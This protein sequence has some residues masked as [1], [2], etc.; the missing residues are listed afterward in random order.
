MSQIQ[1][2]PDPAA[3]PGKKLCVDFALSST[4]FV[5]QKGMLFL[6]V[7]IFPELIHHAALGTVEI[8]FR[9]LFLHLIIKNGS[10]PLGSR[11]LRAKLPTSVAKQRKTS[12]TE[13][14]KTSA[15]SG[16]DVKADAKESSAELAVGAQMRKGE[17]NIRSTGIEDQFSV[18][19][20]V[21]YASGYDSSP[22]WRFKEQQGEAILVGGFSKEKLG[23]LHCATA[24]CGII[25]EFRALQ[26]D[27]FISGASGFFPADLNNSHRAVRKLVIW[28]WLRNKVSPYLNR[29][30]FEVR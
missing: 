28:F 29:K 3:I 7:N 11:G 26:R 6:D 25:A 18:S 4:T 22:C 17:A 21:V 24:E 14:K 2:V 27:M 8:G 15:D 13:E 20:F 9:A 12:Q 10:M 19:Q 16:L 1:E 5:N 30:C 23:E